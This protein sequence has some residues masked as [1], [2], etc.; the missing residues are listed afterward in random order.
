MVEDF[1]LL[2]GIER[3]LLEA[4]INLP[5]RDGCQ[6]MCG[7]KTVMAVTDGFFKSMLAF[8]DTLRTRIADMGHV[9]SLDVPYGTGQMALS[10]TQPPT[11]WSAT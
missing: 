9:Y 1:T 11:S 8:D 5:M 3:D 2:P 10:R 7:M 6:L 4:M